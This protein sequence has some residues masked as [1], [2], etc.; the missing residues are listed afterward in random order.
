LDTVLTIAILDAVL[1][2]CLALY[3]ASQK[4]RS[5]AEGFILGILFGPIGVIVAALLPTLPTQSGR[6]HRPRSLSTSGRRELF[7]ARR[8]LLTNMETPSDDEIARYIR[9]LGSESG[10]CRT[11]AAVTLGR[12]EPNA[13]KAVPALI[14]ALSDEKEHVRRSVANALKRIDP[15]AAS[16]AGVV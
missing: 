12:F 4:N 10:L 3:V 7:Q 9:D 14:E 6:D 13:K 15:E 1:C 11:N 5:P 16:K 2:A 8:D